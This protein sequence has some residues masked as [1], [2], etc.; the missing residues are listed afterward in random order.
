ME[1]VLYLDS[2]ILCLWDSNPVS[3]GHAVVVPRRHFSAWFDASETEQ[4]CMLK[5]IDIARREIERQHQ[6][7]GFNIGINV[8][9]AAGQTIPHL[10]IHVIPRYTGDV[11]D[12]RG[13]VRH[14]IP[15]KGN[16]LVHGDEPPGGITD[17]EDPLTKP[18]VLGSEEYPLLD[19]LA[20]D[21]SQA[22]RI[23]LAVAFVTESGLDEVEPF[24][25]D[26][27][28]RS[29]RMRLLTG[30]YLGFTEPR[31]LLRLLDWVQ[32]FPEQVE[33]RMFQTDH[34]LG[35]HPKAYLISQDYAGATAYIGSSNLTRQALTTG[36]EWNQRIEGSQHDLPLIQIRSEF[37]RLYA[38]ENV[39]PLTQEWI[40]RYK[41]RRPDQ[42]PTNQPPGID[43]AL[44][45]P[46]ESP[47]PNPVQEEALEK[48][49]QTREDGNKAGLVVMATG[50]GK[51]WLAAFDSVGFERVL[52]VAHRE[53]ILN[54]ALS[55]FRKIRP[56]ANF[57]KYMGGQY[58]RQADVL[59]ASVLTLG[60]QNH[61]NY[62]SADHF[63]YIIVDEFH[64]AAASTYRKLIDHFNPKF[65]LGLTATPERTDGGDLLGL[66]GENLVYR[67]DLM[68]GINRELLSPF[69]YFGVPD[70]VDF[71]NIPWRNGRFDPESLDHAVATNRRAQNAW[72]QWQEHGQTKTLAFCVSKRHANFMSE[73]FSGKGARCV[74]VHSGPGSA[75]RTQSL[76]QLEIGD[77]D[78][79]FA[80]DMFNEGV[81][82]PAIDTVM[83]LRPTES[84]IL[85]LQQL[86][87]GLRKAADKAHLAV[88]D[89]IGNHRTFL[90]VPM[91][92]L[93][94]AG[95]RTGEISRA[96]EALD[97]D[98]R[99]ILPN[100]CRVQYELEALNMLKELARPT[101]TVEQITD[102]YRYFKE[103]HGRRPFASEAWHEG[104]DPKKLRRAFGSW[105]GFVKAEEGLSAEESTA[106]EAHRAFL[107]ALEKTPMRK[108]FKM[109]MLLAMIVT[110]KFPGEIGID[111]LS[112][113]VA[114]IAG[115]IRLLKDE[116]EQA[117]NDMA[118]MRRLL[119]PNPIAAWTGGRGMNG[120]R[121]FHY[122][123]QIFS[124]S[125]AIDSDDKAIS[126]LT[127]EICDY[128]LA[129]YLVRLQGATSFAPQIVC[130]VSHSGS[131]PMLFLPAREQNPGIPDG[132]TPVIVG[133]EDYEAKFVRIAVNILRRNGGEE[134][135]L[136]D[137]LR[138][139]FGE[140]AGATGT[141]HQVKFVMRDG[142]YHL[143]PILLD[144]QG[145]DLWREYMRA[146]IPPLF[147]LEFNP[148]SWNK[149]FVFHK[150]SKQM[151]LLATLSNQGM[152]KP[153]Q[154]ID[155]F[156]SRDQIQWHS[157][158][159]TRM[160]T[161]TGQRIKNHKKLGI[162]VH[163]FVRA[164]KKLPDS[165]AAPFVFCG[166]VDFVDWEG[167]Q[168]ITVKWRLLNP[169]SEQLLER[170]SVD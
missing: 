31:V 78:I 137:V 69:H 14:V 81:D 169:I 71:K 86:G 48:L 102:W 2:D 45:Q 159:Q 133:D 8:G 63:D 50:I 51:T 135:S 138:A 164:R 28:D 130:K 54:Q 117:L 167:E 33:V 152:P 162:E 116:F 121:Y 165:T 134:N 56:E 96:L 139:F 131:N 10:H 146:D 57:G 120:V 35:F 61:L 32:E 17:Q 19:S 157:Q 52:F 40:D 90:Q 95:T 79:V 113:Q 105:L 27:F 126:D 70:E 37:E 26:L 148:G 4:A 166:R 110:E 89:Y 58:D 101:G 43:P 22:S 23:D 49:A 123:S 20:N 55:T 160:E 147:G 15:D 142:A 80:V 104:Y 154:Y 82:V 114:R 47:K 3:N 103:Q 109:V 149:G 6:P 99:L 132:W 151:F 153:F 36:L 84:K 115:R 143:S 24:F 128:R 12:P 106:F 136:P 46:T 25:I 64:H 41:Q 85:W 170:F 72:E 34:N 60:K 29:G 158:N 88:I 75:P 156:I 129:Q 21:L 144:S 53:E 62:F 42:T 44:E 76:Q 118:A 77:L 124:S 98:G 73:Y 112:H 145:P 87:R 11:A 97:D 108:S 125:S 127:R 161:P 30:D 168:P 5:G 16:Y 93:P 68:D 100:G 59:F 66:C 155:R 107:E 92:L 141:S 65:L 74:A 150:E 122:E 119:E 38:H 83:M 39:F 91:L 13:G 7:A 163:L 9:E 18:S 67:C 1:G 94:G 140:N 111:E